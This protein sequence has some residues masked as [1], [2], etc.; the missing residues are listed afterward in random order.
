VA[1]S[2]VGRK[3]D[4]LGDGLNKTATTVRQDVKSTRRPTNDESPLTSLGLPNRDA[5]DAVIAMSKTVIFA[6]LFIV[7]GFSSL[8]ICEMRVRLIQ[9]CLSVE[10]A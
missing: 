8:E 3:M 6:T 4:D 5:S 7:L 10:Q 2:G 9:P 1:A